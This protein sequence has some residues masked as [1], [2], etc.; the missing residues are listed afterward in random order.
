MSSIATQRRVFAPTEIDY[1]GEKLVES[2]VWI[3][4]SGRYIQAQPFYATVHYRAAKPS[5]L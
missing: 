3:N 1:S 5:F 2:M 4:K